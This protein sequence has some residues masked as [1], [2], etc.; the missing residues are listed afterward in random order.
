MSKVKVDQSL[1]IG[2]GTCL[3]LCPNLFELNNE[4]KAIVKENADYTSCDTN[5]VIDS[6][7]VAAI[8]KVG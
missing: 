4:G 7:P 6:C 8:S 5:D 2:C 1:C 3:A